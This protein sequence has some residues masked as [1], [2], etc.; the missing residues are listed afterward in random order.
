MGV[1]WDDARTDDTSRTAQAEMVIGAEK[2]FHL[3]FSLN[4]LTLT[5]LKE[6]LVVLFYHRCSVV[7]NSF[8][9]GLRRKGLCAHVTPGC[10]SRQLV[11]NSASRRYSALITLSSHVTASHISLHPPNLLMGYNLTD[12]KHV[13]YIRFFDS[14]LIL[15]LN[16][17]AWDHNFRIQSSCWH[18][19]S[20]SDCIYWPNL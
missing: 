14:F 17:F 10:P 9:A 19:V 2:R 20:I 3:H 11:A 18:S 8:K 4:R 13:S 6:E 12:V 1:W 16:P 5:F 7:L 15:T